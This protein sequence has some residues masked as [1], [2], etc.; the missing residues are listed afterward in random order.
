MASFRKAEM[1][2]IRIDVLW[3]DFQVKGNKISCRLGREFDIIYVIIN[4]FC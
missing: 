2:V 4:F 3:M 1:E